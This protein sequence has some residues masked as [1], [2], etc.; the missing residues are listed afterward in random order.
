MQCTKI[1]IILS[2]SKWGTA[3]AACAARLLINSCSATYL[4]DLETVLRTVIASATQ[5]NN[6]PLITGTDKAMNK[7]CVSE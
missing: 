7:I 6:I 4:L 3:A 1:L 5:I 2:I